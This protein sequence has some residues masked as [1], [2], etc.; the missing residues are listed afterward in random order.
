MRLSQMEPLGVKR[1]D[2]G[3][4]QKRLTF[5]SDLASVGYGQHRDYS[6]QNTVELALMAALIA[7]GLSPSRAVAVARPFVISATSPGVYRGTLRKWLVFPAGDHTRAIATNEPDLAK[8]S[9]SLA[10]PP[11]FNFVDIGG[12]LQRIDNLFLASQED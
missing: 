1:A 4:W 12:L 10:C 7:A 9:E 11:T 6:Y 2:V 3:N 8:L 5:T